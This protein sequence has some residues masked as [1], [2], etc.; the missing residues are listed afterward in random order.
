MLITE[1]RTPQN[2]TCM[3][4]LLLSIALGNAVLSVLMEIVVLACPFLKGISE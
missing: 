2:I 1:G 4:V 3:Y